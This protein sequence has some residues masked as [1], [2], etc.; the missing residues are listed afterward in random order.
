MR[1]LYFFSLNPLATG[2]TQSLVLAGVSLII[3]VQFFAL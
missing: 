2:K 3:A 1:F